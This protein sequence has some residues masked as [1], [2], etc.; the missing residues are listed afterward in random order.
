MPEEPL[1]EDPDLKIAVFTKDP[2]SHEIHILKSG[3]RYLLQRGILRELATTSR[4]RLED[5]LN[6]VNHA[7]LDDARQYGLNADSIGLAIAQAYIEEEERFRREG[8]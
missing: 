8:L 6:R 1:Y 5:K 2:E 7:I 4:E 3:M